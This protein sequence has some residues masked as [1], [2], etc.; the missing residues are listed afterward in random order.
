[1]YKYSNSF[2]FIDLKFWL[3]NIL[4][5]VFS[6]LFPIVKKLF[7]TLFL[8]LS[9]LK[10]IFNEE[11]LISKYSTALDKI[12]LKKIF[13]SFFFLSSSNKHPQWLL[14][15]KVLYSLKSFN[16]FISSFNN[17]VNIYIKLFSKERKDKILL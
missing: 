15:K 16:L 7:S 4:F 17:K 6:S 10:L 13:I 12:A 8:I 14:S 1:M 5:K 11:W 3:L 2:L 9:N